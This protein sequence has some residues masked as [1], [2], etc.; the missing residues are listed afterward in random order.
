MDVLLSAKLLLL[1]LIANGL[2]VLAALVL[3]NRVNTPLDGGARLPDGQPLLGASKTLRGILVS[4]GGTP[5]L[6][7][8]LGY[9]ALTGLQFA[10]LAMLGDLLS[11]FTK[12]RLR[13]PSSCSVP[14]L[15][16]LPETL[17]PLL[18]LQ[19]VLGASAGEIAVA[20]I[21][22]VVIDLLLGDIP[23]RLRRRRGGAG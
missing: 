6:A 4:I 7:P 14:L 10:L 13:K 22:F 19:P 16:Q 9:S 15:D 2:P 1:L 20:T 12:R 18:V 5:L 11:S 21:A 23:G 8:L 3:G 17:L